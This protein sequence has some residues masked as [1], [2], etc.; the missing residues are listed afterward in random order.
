MILS[1][2]D[3]A[4]TAGARFRIQ[5]FMTPLEDGAKYAK[6]VPSGAKRGEE[7]SGL[8]KRMS[9]GMSSSDVVEAESEIEV[10]ALLLSRPHLLIVLPAT[11]LHF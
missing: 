8:P 11:P 3:S 7:Y 1:L 2:F 4:D 10:V 9:R 6:R 5:M